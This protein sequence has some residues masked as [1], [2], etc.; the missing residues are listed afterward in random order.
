MTAHTPG[1]ERADA[2]GLVGGG[3]L[4]DHIATRLLDA[5]RRLVMLNRDQQQTRRYVALGASDVANAFYLTSAVDTVLLDL[6][7]VHALVSVMEGPDGVLSA[8]APGQVV[9][10]LGASVPSSDRRLAALVAARG[11][12]M[13]DAPLIRHGEHLIAP[14]GGSPDAF[15]SARS[16]LELLAQRVAYVGPSGFGQLTTLLDQMLRAARTVALAEGLSFARRV[17]LDSSLTADLLDLPDAEPM[18]QG[19][20]DG[21]GELRQHT[22]DLGYALEVAQEAGL[23]AP[24]TAMTNEIYKAV[25]AHGDSSWQEA[26]I[27]RYWE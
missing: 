4:T 6:P 16:L 26:A 5:G 15:Q 22:R 19:A 2:V 24:L 18:L 25:A 20:F 1:S 14:V 27:I 12:Q 10:N 7:D 17:G 8:L 9:I 13:L 3:Y 23:L 11:G 21:Q